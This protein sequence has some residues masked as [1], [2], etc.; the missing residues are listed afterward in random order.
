MDLL[1]LFS[2]IGGFSLAWKWCGGKTIQFVEIDPFCQ[3]VLAKNFPGVPIHDDIKTF[4]YT[5]RNGCDGAEKQ[6]GIGES[7]REGGLRESQGLYGTS[8][9]LREIH[10][11]LLTGGFPCQPFS[12]AGKRRG[13]EDDRYLWPEMLRVVSEARPTW[14]IGENVAG[15]INMGLDDCISDLEGEGYEVQAFVIPACAVGAPHRRDRVWIVGKL[16]DD[17]SLNGR[18]AVTDTGGGGFGRQK[19]RTQQPERAEVISTDSDRHAPDTGLQGLEKREVFG[20]DIQKEC[21]AIVGNAWQEPWLEAAQRFCRLDDG[22]PDRLVRYSLRNE[23]R[24][25][26]LKALGNT[27]VPQIAYIIMKAILESTDGSR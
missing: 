23:H 15:F 11:F 5:E 25:Q 21:Q 3:K 12:C 17:D 4:T 20:C 10:P 9:E 7:E 8:R 13:K 16:N 2:G 19:L 18:G 1:S 24:V 27:I 14:V 6:G 26:K 22:L